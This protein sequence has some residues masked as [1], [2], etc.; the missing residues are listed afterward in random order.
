MIKKTKSQSVQ[1]EKEGDS[2]KQG[3]RRER[4]RAVQQGREVMAESLKNIRSLSPKDISAVTL[5]QQAAL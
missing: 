1:I 4:E 3:R 5:Y 2:A